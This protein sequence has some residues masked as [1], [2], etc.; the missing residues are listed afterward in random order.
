MTLSVACAVAIAARLA[1][2]FADVLPGLRRLSG[3]ERLPDQW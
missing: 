3:G 2:A 1:V